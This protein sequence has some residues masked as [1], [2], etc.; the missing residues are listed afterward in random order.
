MALM[1]L[2]M[3]SCAQ[4]FR[5]A[6]A[7][8]VKSL[9]EDT[10][11]TEM[12]TRV[13]SSA[14]EEGHIRVYLTDEFNF[15]AKKV[16]REDGSFPIDEVKSE[17]LEFVTIL[18]VKKM[19]RTFPYAGKFEARTVAAGLDK[20]YDIWFDESF[21]VEQAVQALAGTKQFEK[22]ECRPV[23]TRFFESTGEPL[24]MPV[25]GMNSA[26]APAA[27]TT[28]NDPML[29]D[30]WHYF[31]DQTK[32]GYAAGCDINVVP[33]W[34]SATKGNPDIVVAVV[35]E[36]VQYDHPDL[37]AN[38][39]H[40]PSN[41]QQPYGRNFA[42]NTYEIHP[43]D[44]GTHVAGT[45]SAV[46]NNGI[47]VC[48]IA[49]GDA[50]A[51][52]KGVSIMS[53]QIFDGEKDGSGA[54]A[55]KWAADHGAVIAQNSWGYPTLTYLPASDRSAIDYFNTYAGIDENGDQVGPMAGGIVIFAA[56]NEN[57]DYGYP[58]EYEGA[59]AVA[60][61]GAD[62]NKA[63][64][65]DYGD[66]IDVAAP[67]GDMKKGTAVVSTLSGSQYGRMQ[68]TSMA[69]PHVSGVAA[70][71]LSKFGGMG[72]TRDMLWNRLVNTT[73]SVT[74]TKYNRT[75]YVAGLVD[76]LAATATF[77]TVAPEKVAEFSAE[78]LNSNFVKLSVKVPADEDDGAAFGVNVYYDTEP[79][80]STARIPA[81]S[82]RFGSVGVGETFTDTLSG[83]G[84][85][86]TYYLR[87]MAYDLSGNLSE[88][89]DEVV[90]TTS[91]NQAPVIK[92]PDKLSFDI[93]A[94]ETVYVPFSYSDPDG[95]MM[96][97]YLISD[98]RADS[99][100]ITGMSKAQIVIDGR[101]GEPGTYTSTVVVKDE[102]DAVSEFEY[103]FTLNENHAPVKYK[104]IPNQLF[105]K[106][107]VPAEYDFSEFVR[108]A[109][110]EILK[111]NIQDS[112]LGVVNTA[113]MNGRLFITPLKQGT[114][115]VTLIASD[116]FDETVILTF[117]VVVRDGDSPLSI[118]PNPVKDKLYIAGGLEQSKIHVTVSAQTGKI[119]YDE[120]MNASAFAPGIVDMST[121]APGI[122][123]VTVEMDGNTYTKNIVKI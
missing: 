1:S 69:C 39:W 10:I 49:G 90:V 15:K 20:W 116:A 84:F 61:V 43:G 91:K 41:R 79:I 80:V 113:V 62:F 44:H 36:G 5:Q 51:G 6:S 120:D 65:S 35:D 82:F 12:G 58:G 7:D 92:R 33:V 50:Q 30:Q 85:N 102:F 32:S 26:A 86:T 71:I 118:Y 48:G 22:A 117:D 25:P 83:L 109:D 47:G 73:N 111:I 87:C 122:Y 108:D 28:F 101:R 23:T 38:M 63:Y 76:A 42:S 9:E 105:T 100:Q 18:G 59:I 27:A 110:D 40:N 57:R 78:A 34:E 77:G 89:S 52:I 112:G 106:L 98:S 103:T 94:H 2:I 119:V 96:S 95:H 72:F 24:L 123:L 55:I 8:D 88:L 29:K 16:L 37:A 67:G 64:Y 114:D 121:C 53:C 97:P 99:L 81:K 68:G 3:T 75:T 93:R 46:N 60:S 104:D 54:T 11:L 115:H 14:I 66:W 13:P 56:G 31:N 17:E 45:I 4:D 74:Y 107:G 21:P 70:L 19:C